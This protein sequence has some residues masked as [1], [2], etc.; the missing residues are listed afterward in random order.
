MSTAVATEPRQEGMIMISLVA[1]M[2]PLMIAAMAFSTVMGGRA[3]GY[4]VDYEEEMALLA[5]E[6]GVDYSIYKSRLGQLYDGVAISKAINLGQAFSIE[7]TDLHSDGVD[8]DNDTLVDEPDE[9]VFQ[10]IVV[11]TYRNRVRRIAAYLGPVGLVPSITGAMMSQDPGIDIQLSGSSLISGTDKK[12]DG[13]AGAGP[14]QSGFVVAAPGT[15]ASLL[16]VLTVSEQNKIQGLGGSPSL[17]AQPAIDLTVLV[18]QVKN[19]ASVVLASD[20]YTTY[21]FGDGPMGTA[22]ITYREGDVQFK[23][24]SQGAG[25]LVVTGDLSI[26]GTF[27]FDGVIVCLG[28]FQNSAGNATVNGS[29]LLGPSS[30]LVEGTGNL[31]VQYSAEAVALA[32][33]LGG[34]QVMFNGWQEISRK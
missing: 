7:P 25:I 8:N 4:R 28:R 17:Q 24:N 3:S 14:D 12:M 27:R 11:G 23:G 6:S 15:V 20:K 29:I 13:T 33:S 22:Y 9:N 21:K 1:I 10:V 19:T 30:S 5:A 26:S 31:T 18:D 34:G 2:I 16:S 32:N